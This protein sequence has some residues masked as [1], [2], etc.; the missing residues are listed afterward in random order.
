MRSPVNRLCMGVCVCVFVW[1]ALVTSNGVE[2]GLEKGKQHIQ[3]KK[4]LPDRNNMCPNYSW[5]FVM[6]S[7]LLS[8]FPS[9]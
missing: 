7:S 9:E 2:I 8:R 1:V 5:R 4:G 6:A 3:Q